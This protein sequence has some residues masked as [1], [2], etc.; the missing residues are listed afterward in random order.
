[1]GT[2]QYKLLAV[3][4]LGF[5]L[6]GC[7]STN[8]GTVVERASF[9]AGDSFSRTLYTISGNR[10]SQWELTYNEEHK[11]RVAERRLSD[12]AVQA[13]W[14]SLDE[15]EVG[16]WRPLYDQTHV[17]GRTAYGDWQLDVVRKGVV[18]HCEGGDAYPTDSDPRKTV[19]LKSTLRFAKVWNAFRSLF[20]P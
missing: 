7:K 8:T 3:L 18:I 4:L 5:S 11:K 15:A 19:D 10:A 1:M 14:R 2:H 12:T 16:K 6:S 9:K 13:F 17:D 20:D